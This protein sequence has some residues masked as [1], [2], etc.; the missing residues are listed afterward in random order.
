MKSAIT[1]ADA[2][3]ILDGVGAGAR[4]SA[5]GELAAAMPANLKGADLGKILGNTQDGDRLNALHALIA[6]RKVSAG[7]SGE[8]LKPL[9]AGMNEQTRDSALGQLLTVK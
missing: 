9:L 8:E 7:L 1:V 2:E 3:L 5:I 6:A 4:A